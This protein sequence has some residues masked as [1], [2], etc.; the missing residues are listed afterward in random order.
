MAVIELNDKNFEKEVVKSEIP[1][2]VDFYADWCGPCLML[3]PIF[4]ELSKDFSGKIKF[5]K[6]NTSYFPDIASSYGIS[7]IPCLIFLEK[8]KE[9]ERIIGL[10]P[11]K[12]LKEKI[13]S[14]I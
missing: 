4:E 14:M 8:G 1:V 10:M 6:I 13:D 7:G 12:E 3:K 11:K 2:L 9:K 5:A